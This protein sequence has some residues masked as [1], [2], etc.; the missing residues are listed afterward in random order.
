[1]QSGELTKGRRELNENTHENLNGDLKNLSKE[2]GPLSAQQ[3]RSRYGKVTRVFVAILVCFILVAAA[4]TGLVY[5]LLQGNAG[6][7]SGI[8]ARMEQ[9]LEELAGDQFDVQINSIDLDFSRIGNLTIKSDSIKVIRRTDNEVLSDI[10]S[11]EVST[12]LY[13]ILFGAGNF[14]YARINEAWF[15][16]ALLNS[17]KK[18]FL[19]A[20]LHKPLDATGETL[21]RLHNTFSADE[22]EGFEIY[23]STISGPVLGRKRSDPITIDRLS[24]TTINSQSFSASG[25]LR[26]ELSDVEFTSRYSAQADKK[27]SAEYTFNASG[28]DLREWLADPSTDTGVVGSDSLIS[29][30]GSLPFDENN[31]ALDPN[32]LIKTSPSTLRIGLFASS[33]IKRGDLNFRLILDRNQIELDPS[34]VEIG[35]LKAT[36]LGGIKPADAAAGYFGSLRYDIIMKRGEFEPTLEGEKVVPAAFKMAGIYN[37]E[38]EELSVDNIVLTTMSG[39]IK[40]SGSIGLKGETPSIKAS[41]STDGISVTA[42]KQFWPFFVAGGARKWIHDHIIDGHVSSGTVTADVPSGVIFRLRQGAK[43]APENYKTVLNVEDFK[44]RPFGE[45]PP[46]SNAK[47][48]VTL[49]GMQISADMTEG[50]VTEFEGD[51]VKILSGSF[52]MKD[53]AAKE[54]W[55][56]TKLELDGDIKTIAK[57]SDRKPLRIMER[58]KV[59]SEQFSGE[60][61]ANI[62]ARFPVGRKAKYEEVEWNVLL[63]LENGNS[64]KELAGRKIANAD[65]LV[66][67][68]PTGAKVTGTMNIDGVLSKVNLVEPI[69]KSGK[70]KRKREVRTIVNEKERL[71]LGIN[72]KPIVEGPVGLVVVQNGNVEKYKLDFAKARISLPWVGWTKGAD[73]PAEGEFILKRLKSG[74]KLEKFK[75]SGPGFDGAGTLVIDKRG[76]VS[77]DIKKLKLNETDDMQLKVERTKSAYNVNASGLSYDARGV[78]NTL[79]HKGGFGKAQ[80]DRSVNLVANFDT[81]RGFGGRVIRNAILLY[82]SRNGSLYKLDMQGQGSDGRVYNVQAQLNGNQTLFTVKTNDA[83]TALAF[84][85]IYSLMERGQLEANLIQTENGPYSG[86]VRI[87]EFTLVN[88]PRLKR[89]AS[90]VRRQ[91]REDRDE[92]VQIINESPDNKVKMKLADAHIERGNGYFKLNDAIIRGASMGISMNGTVYDP[93]DRMNI[94]GTFMPANGLNLAVSSIPV[95]GKLLS[96]GRDNG[97]IGV[98]YQLKGPRTNPELVV[99][100][101]SI[102]TPGVFN[103]VFEFKQ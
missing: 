70:T 19:P 78:M 62:A 69:G 46:I 77:A 86:P 50:E 22:F 75:L 74:V 5:F 64:K 98:T 96:N 18:F 89:I 71:A 94:S 34:E 59:G 33:Q 99:N 1:M 49:E 13:S 39:S 41:A 20:Q 30:N 2:R 44:F 100:P 67:A 40:G 17:G 81:V 90:N 47:G 6:K 14:D 53:F 25:L 21:A 45:M 57:I 65:L 56:E 102:V 63:E 4:G 9:A 16:A 95:L 88:E 37:R 97:L 31:K 101:L 84:T 80:G 10:G 26:T 93:E 43:L 3:R 54:R 103:K 72:L 12:R 51:P 15:N 82:E 28:I 36:L 23:N 55:G 68:N 42:L 35:R 87:T 79:I 27:R 73:I 52:V 85:N 58:M 38:E 7:E 8:V 76:L 60:G 66:D 92:R 83:G 61:H 48:V 91:L 11:F 29:V 32:V 24:I